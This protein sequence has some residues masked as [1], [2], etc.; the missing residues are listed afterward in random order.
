MYAPFP[1]KSAAGNIPQT[2]SRLDPLLASRIAVGRPS[3]SVHQINPTPV[4]ALRSCEQFVIPFVVV[5]VDVNEQTSPRIGGADSP[6]HGARSGTA[7]ERRG[8]GAEERALMPK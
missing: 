6:D 2:A 3:P 4:P 8:R 7:E 1:G 5:D